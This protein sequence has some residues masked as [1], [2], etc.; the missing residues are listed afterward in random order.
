MTDTEE[1]CTP[2]FESVDATKL[3]VYVSCRGG[4][5]SGEMEVELLTDFSVSCVYKEDFTVWFLFRPSDV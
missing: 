4:Q 2:V 1:L 3:A 5:G